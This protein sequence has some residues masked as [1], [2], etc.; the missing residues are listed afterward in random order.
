[1]KINEAIV[2]I[3]ASCR[4]GMAAGQ[5][6]DVINAERLHVRRDGNPVSCSHVYAAVC[7]SPEVF[8]KEGGLIRLLM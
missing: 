4:R 3:L 1:M 8:T 6:A 2:Y 5:L 7:R